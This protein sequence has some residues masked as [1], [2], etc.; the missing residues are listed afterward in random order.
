[1]DAIDWK[2]VAVIGEYTVPAGPY[3]EDHFLVIVFRSGQITE[4][5]WAKAREI[6]PGLQDALRFEIV[7][8]LCNVT[9]TASRIIFPAE[10]SE[11]PVFD[12][13]QSK[14]GVRKLLRAI[15]HFGVTEISKRLTW[16]V[17]DYLRRK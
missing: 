9:K 1:M 11:R 14:W 16:E 13:Y 2:S 10:M 4:Y 7:S 5:S 12:F 8:R 6:I 17:E 3:F 15:R